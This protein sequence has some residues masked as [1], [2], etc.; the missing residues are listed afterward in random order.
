MFEFCK[1]FTPISTLKFPNYRH[2]VITINEYKKTMFY[3]E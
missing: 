1:Y 3:A 2:V